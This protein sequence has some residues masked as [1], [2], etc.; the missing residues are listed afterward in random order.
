MQWSISLT[1]GWSMIHAAGLL[2]GE[3]HVWPD[4]RLSPAGRQLLRVQRLRAQVQAGQWRPQ[5][6][7]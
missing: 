1:E 3:T 5:V 7:L 6:D 4:P 2:H